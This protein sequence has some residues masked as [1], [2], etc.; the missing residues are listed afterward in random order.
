MK[1]TSVLS[2]ARKGDYPGCSSCPSSPTNFINPAYGESCQTHGIDWKA[3]DSAISVM[4]VRDPANTTAALGKL[5]FVCNSSNPTDGT[6]RHAYDLWRAAVAQE[7][8]PTE[9]TH[10]LLKGHYWTNASLHGTNKHNVPAARRQCVDV[11]GAQIESLSPLILIASG[12][13]AA[14]SLYELGFIS[15]NWDGFR[16]GLASGVYSESRTRSNGQLVTTFCTYHTSV[17]VVNRTVSGRHSGETE[18]LLTAIRSASP[19]TDHI[20]AF[21]QRYPAGTTEGNGM[22]VLLL[23]WL[24]IGNAIREAH[25]FKQKY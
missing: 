24:E 14:Q 16:R 8:Q 3:T 18:D 22:R 2:R 1:I 9:D 12:S 25:G 10:R 21:L 11:L 15:K 4:V 19:I 6:A 5:C 20:D 7:W 13:D 17:G 23:H